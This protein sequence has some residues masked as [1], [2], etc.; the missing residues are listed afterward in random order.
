MGACND[1]ETANYGMYVQV[2]EW[3][4]ITDPDFQ[5]RSFA[6]DVSLAKWEHAWS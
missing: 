2:V 4:Q 5:I 6:A 3:N 1:T